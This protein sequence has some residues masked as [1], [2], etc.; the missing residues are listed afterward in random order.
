MIYYAEYYQVVLC[1]YAFNAVLLLKMLHI[2][3][4]MNIPV[5]TFVKS[6]Q[7]S[8]TTEQK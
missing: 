3:E 4:P 1:K 7:S 6:T 8:A 5:V 2:T